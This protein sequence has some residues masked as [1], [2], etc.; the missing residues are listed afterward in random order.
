MIGT[1]EG[2]VYK[3]NTAMRISKKFK[4]HEMS[5]NRIDYNNFDMNVF[6]TCS[7]DFMV[8]LWENNSE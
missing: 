5:I 3:C 4:A 1:T 2:Y 6:V 7:D 8:K